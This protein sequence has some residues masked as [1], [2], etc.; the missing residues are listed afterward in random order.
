ME[1]SLYTRVLCSQT[2]WLELDL[3]DLMVS[4]GS[5]P[6]PSWWQAWVV[7]LLVHPISC[8]RSTLRPH[9][10]W[11]SRTPAWIHQLTHLNT[12][13]P[14]SCLNGSIMDVIYEVFPW[15]LYTNRS[16]IVLLGQ[17]CLSHQHW[18]VIERKTSI[19]LKFKSSKWVQ[20]PHPSPSAFIQ[21]L[22]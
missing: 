3:I 22:A 21:C 17:L 7:I 20:K 12:T 19:T 4:V 10:H 13:T 5:E 8:S 6:A 18:D 16:V 2:R 15:S 14:V 1:A 9:F 11:L